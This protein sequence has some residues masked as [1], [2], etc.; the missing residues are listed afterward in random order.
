MK[1]GVI[2]KFVGLKAVIRPDDFGI[3]RRDVIF[4]KTKDYKHGDRVEFRVETKN[5]RCHAFDVKKI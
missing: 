1:Q 3:V 5:G 4:D 2:Y